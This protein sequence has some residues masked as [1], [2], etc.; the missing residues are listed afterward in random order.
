[1]DGLKEVENIENTLKVFWK[2]LFFS[3]ALLELSVKF[4]DYGVMRTIR[5][6]IIGHQTCIWQ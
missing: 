5:F 3:V 4:C 1:M 2:L 6:G